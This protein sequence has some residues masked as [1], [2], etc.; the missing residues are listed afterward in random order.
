MKYKSLE[1]YTLGRFAVKINNKNLISDNCK[2][3]KKWIL[4][5]YLF[6]NCGRPVSRERLISVLRLEKNDDPQAALTA[7]VYRLR[8][9]LREINKRSDFVPYISTQGEAYIF[10]DKA[11]YWLDAEEFKNLCRKTI[12]LI[13]EE[14]TDA[15]ETFRKA[16]ALYQG[17]YLEET[18]TE[19]WVWSSR[20]SYRELFIETMIKL[21]NFMQER[22][23]YEELWKL[24]EDILEDVKFEEELILG[25]VRVLLNSGYQGLARIKYEEAVNL[26]RDNDLQ[27]PPD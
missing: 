22:K 14:N 7:L 1:I 18:R 10:N 19:E 6:T 23:L 26:F 25:S 5:Q 16:I 21:D 3:S 2:L 9:T 12:N 20:S 17:D 4:L 27:I 13:T 11:N 8:K 24:Y 15:I